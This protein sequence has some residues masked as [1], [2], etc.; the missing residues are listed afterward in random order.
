MLEPVNVDTPKNKDT[1]TQKLILLHYPTVQRNLQYE[2]K[3]IDQIVE[4]FTNA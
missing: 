4:T 2:A 1:H 3:S